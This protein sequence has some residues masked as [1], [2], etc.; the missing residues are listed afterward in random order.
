ML[1]T[2]LTNLKNSIIMM[3]FLTFEVAY[4]FVFSQLICVLFFNISNAYGAVMGMLVG[5]LLT[6]LSGEPSLG[7]APVLHFPGCSLEDGVYVQYS[8]VKTISMLSAFSANLLFSYLASVLFNNGWLP[9]KWD[10]F[11]VKAQRSPQPLTPAG[12]TSGHTEPEEF[13]QKHPDASEPMISTTC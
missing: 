2:S 9:E 11:R 8:P 7:I 1:G 4:I 12:G 13:D 5:S 6:L 3:V 10:V